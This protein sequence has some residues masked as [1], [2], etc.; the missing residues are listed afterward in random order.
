MAPKAEEPKFCKE[1]PFQTRFL[2]QG[3]PEKIQMHLKEV[4]KL[5][6]ACVNGSSGLWLGQSKWGQCKPGS[7]L[8]EQNTGHD[9]CKGWRAEAGLPRGGQPM[10][11]NGGHLQRCPV[12]T[13][14]ASGRTHRIDV[15]PKCKLGANSAFEAPGGGKKAF[16]LYPCGHQLDRWSA[17]EPPYI[18]CQTSNCKLD[19]NPAL[20]RRGLGDNPRKLPLGGHELLLLWVSAV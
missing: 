15:F 9:I 12:N 18:V 6:D 10:G 2:A 14:C 3:R 4:A 19:P 1:K 16:C 8:L 5:L 20:E 7:L 17:R 13:W 11:D